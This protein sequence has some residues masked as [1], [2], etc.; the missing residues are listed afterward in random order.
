MAT[1][2]TTL[3]GLGVQG[4]DKSSTPDHMATTTIRVD[5]ETHAALL[6]IGEAEPEASLQVHRIVATLLGH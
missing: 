1:P 2:S 3:A 4:V 5:T 6:Q